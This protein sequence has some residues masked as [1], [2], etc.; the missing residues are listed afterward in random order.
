MPNKE[1]HTYYRSRLE[2]FVIIA[3]GKRKGEVGGCEGGCVEYL[4]NTR[5]TSIY[6]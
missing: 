6:F 2:L 3:G 4:S 1:L 5:D